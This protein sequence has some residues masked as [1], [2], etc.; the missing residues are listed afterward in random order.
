M[1]DAEEQWM[2]L[3]RELFGDDAEEALDQMRHMG[4]DPSA[5]AQASGMANAPGMMDHMLSQIRALMSQSQGEDVN[6]TL[7]HDV[8]RGVAAQGGD[9]MISAAQAREYRAAVTEAELWLDAATDFDPARAQPA[10]WSRAEWV[11][12]TLPKWRFLAGPVASSVSLALG[13][14]LSD[15]SGM[16]DGPNAQG[17][18]GSVSPTVCGMH[19]GQAAGA[20]AR[21]A[22]G[23]TDL[24]IPLLDEARVVMV[25]QQ[26]EEFA[27]GLDIDMA[28]VRLFLALR[29]AAHVRLFAS[30][31]W[32]PGQLHAA[33]ER[34][35]RGVTVDLDALD[36]AV[37][38][39]GMG[40]P[41]ALQKALTTGIFAPTHTPEQVETLAAIETWLALIEGWVDE[42]T[43]RAAAPHLSAL[44]PLREMMRRRR[45]AGGP[46][47]D[48]FSG[49]L[50]LTLRP[51]RLRDAADMWATLTD[52]LGTSAR[53]ALWRHPDL[54]PEAENLAD[55]KTWVER[56]TGEKRAD[57]IDREIEALLS[58]TWEGPDEGP[59]GESDTTSGA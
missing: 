40:D 48:T 36:N 33:I 27:E 6:W 56:A 54:L 9:P 30:A 31:P 41:A 29:E 7:A 15:D 11:E 26:V 3:L 45:A 59:D 5:L 20:M 44:G 49:L 23:A 18:I 2:K 38:D 34:Y 46:A 43:A 10:V 47:E 22:F 58:G 35:A 24:G 8:A 55:W 25:P 39:A 28:D 21:E 13:G 1:A 12:A 51:R 50:G 32:L 57:D 4:M 14:V 17:L 37:R 19:M 53:D 42:V 52:R 16:L